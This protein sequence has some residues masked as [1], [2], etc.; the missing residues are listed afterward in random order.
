LPVYGLKEKELKDYH[1][2]KSDANNGVFKIPMKIFRLKNE[3]K[4]KDFPNNIN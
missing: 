1:T 3:D 2:S 4:Y